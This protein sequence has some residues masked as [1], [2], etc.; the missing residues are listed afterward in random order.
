M[1][2]KRTVNDLEVEKVLSLVRSFCLSDE[3]RN[4]ISSQLFTSD[5]AVIYSRAE[6]IEL[7][8]GRIM[9]NE[10]S[11]SSF[12]SLSSLF[13]SYDAHAAQ[14]AGSEIHNVS[15]FISALSDLAAFEEDPLLCDKELKDLGREISSS[16][17]ADGTVRET[18]PL[19]LPLVRALDSERAK[20]ARFARMAIS[21]QPALFQSQDAVF[22]NERVV[23][24]VRREMRAQVRGYIHSSSA[25]GST[26]YVE[27]FE[28]VDLNNQVSLA[29]DEII[30][31]KHK[32]LSDLSAR[33]RSF[34]PLLRERTEY[35]RIF[36]FHY[37][38]A[39][40]VIRTKCSR[41][42]FSDEI[43][44]VNAR[45]PLL[46]DA[47]VPISLSVR[48]ECRVV[49]LSGPNAGGKTVTMKTVAL[50]AVLSQISGYAPF[51]EGS[52]LPLYETIYTDIGDGQS[53]LENFSTFSAHMSNIASICSQADSRSLVL[54]DEIGS[55]T[56]P[57]E[58]ECLTDSLLDYFKSRGVML[59]IT[60]HYSRIKLHA[61]TDREMMNAS[62]DF[63]LSRNMPT[64][65]IIEGLPGDSHAFEIARR[66]GLPRSVVDSARARMSSDSSIASIV[67][68]LNSRAS[69]LDRKISEAANE[70]NRYQKLVK[71]LGEKEAE[72]D[73][74]R[75]SYNQD[76][77]DE[78]RLWLKEARKRLENLVRDV[79][80]GRLTS[81]KTHEVKAFISDA[82]K[83]TSEAEKR[84]GAERQ[85]TLG[86]L[87][88]YRPGDE[89]LCGQMKRRG[90]ITKDLGKGMYQVTIDSMKISL[91]AD[92]L[93]PAPAEK[94]ASVSPYKVTVAPPKAGLDLRGCTL[95][96]ALSAIDDEIES[97]LVHS[98]SSFSIIHGFGNGVL[99]RGIHD[100]LKKH[101]A[102]ADYYFADPPDGGMGKTYVILG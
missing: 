56:D 50:L 80:T 41:A 92:T 46:F 43:R 62:M 67:K 65:R 22:R 11:L 7:I 4:Y 28:L 98:V 100:Y 42:A 99:S 91:S 86:Q 66:M 82:E 23:L 47:A 85:K 95:A 88:Q 1:I 69:Q 64:F 51:D 5:E 102:V 37:A 83:K 97:C 18:H 20:R 26:L 30:R 38:F 73:R 55:G 93:S 75:A 40:Y 8:T 74:I 12:V 94:K 17:E 77:A 96:Q 49:V 60:S 71:E 90:V 53:I 16:L 19:L 89:V 32:I 48:P 15:Q 9:A 63:D 78:M 3:G 24:P 45:H 79:Q 101:K 61:Y 54:L 2:S 25:T 34:I 13:D 29:E 27:P 39:M 33:V 14:F 70:K 76:T 68:G 6:R 57:Q 84:A 87:Q 10:H 59:F 44:L 31:M 81:G 72:L 35:V 58:G 36:D 52:S 21:Q